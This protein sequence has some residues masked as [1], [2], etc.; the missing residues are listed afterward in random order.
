MQRPEVAKLRA[1]LELLAGVGYDSAARPAPGTLD[2]TRFAFAFLRRWAGPV[3]DSRKSA[4]HIASGG[5][6]WE[7]I[8]A[9]VELGLGSEIEVIEP[10]WYYCQGWRARWS[11]GHCFWWRQGRQAQGL[12]IQATNGGY[13]WVEPRTWEEQCARFPVG[14]RAVRI[15]ADWVG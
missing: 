5:G 11:G 8:E 14:V 12:I 1:C 13:P 7:N 2:C 4:L 6:P 15:D 9:V 3:V 10:G